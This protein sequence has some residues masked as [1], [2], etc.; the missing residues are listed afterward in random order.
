MRPRRLV[1]TLLALTLLVVPATATAKT[2]RAPAL[3]SPAAGALVEGVPAITW[4]AVKGAVAYEYQIAADPGF[5]S[6]V[7]GSGRGKGTNKTTNSAAALTSTLPDGDYHWRVR[8]IDTSDRAGRWSAT[9]Q[10][11]KAWTTA[12]LLLEPADDFAVQWPSLPLVLRWSPVPY[13]TRYV[14][15]IATDQ[16][17]ASPVIGTTARPQ[18]TQGT[19]FALPA[20][21]ANG[22]RYYWA[23]TPRDADGHS[24]QRSRSGSFTWNW[25]SAT[26]TRFADLDGDPGVLD[27]LF[28]WDA[29]PGAA[30]YEVDVN[31][32]QD[33]SPSSRVCCT[34]KTIGT[35][36]AP[37]RPFANNDGSNG[38]GYYW[39]M[40]AFDAGGNAGQWNYDPAF[41]PKGFH[42]AA[43]SIPNIQVRDNTFGGLSGPDLSTSAPVVTW[44]PVAGA[45][46][47]E[48]QLAPWVSG[49]SCAWTGPRIETVTGSTAW[50]PTESGG[51]PG[52]SSWPPLTPPDS[53]ALQ[54]GTKY[55]VRILA[56]SDR[57]GADLNGYISPFTTVAPAFT[58]TAPDPPTP[59]PVDL[60]MSEADYLFPVTGTFPAGSPTAETPLFRWKRVPWA[61][62]YYVVIARD[63]NFTQVVDIARTKIPAYAPR[64]RPNPGVPLVDETTSYYWAVM[65]VGPGEAT[66]PISEDNAQSFDKRSIPPAAVS[67]AQDAIVS[68]QP[69]FR[70][71]PRLGTRRYQLQVSQDP[72]FAADSLI[73][74]V[75]TSST[76]YTSS[77]TYPAD[78]VVYW[79]LRALDENLKGQTWSCRAPV[80][81]RCAT[82]DPT[83][84]DALKTYY[85]SFQRVLP[86][87]SPFSGNPTGGLGIPVLSWNPVPGAISYD[88]HADWVDGRT[89]DT[90][91]SSTAFTPTSFFGNGIWRWKVR[92][93]F[94]SGA[95]GKVSGGYFPAQDY[96]RR[97]DRTPNVRGENTSTR[98]LLSWDPD[99]AAAR[100]R[101]EISRSNAFGRTL[102]QVDTRT[103]AFAPDIASGAY[104][105]G[106]TYHW[107]VAS[108]D[109][110]R[111]T[112]AW[113][114]GTFVLPKAFRVTVS[115]LLRKGRRGIATAFVRGADRR[116][117]RGARVRVTG[118]G[119]RSATRKTNREGAAAFKLRP[120]RASTLTFTITRKGYRD[121]T[122]TLVVR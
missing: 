72:S 27:P 26:K 57:P 48:V 11:T 95:S 10:F 60:S 12:P 101:V 36:V 99:P 50:T 108:V 23:I 17:L 4:S 31:F 47:Y 117:V 41:F 37:T 106:G 120:R 121:A 100:Y 29:V 65:P 6:V 62:G 56:R 34:D 13:A 122:A 20:S 16:A 3:V 113:T 92:A 22:Q 77:T 94:P 14:V 2:L 51:N 64:L 63:S 90:T 87:P 74:D 83:N 105:D 104:A 42:A 98:V 8:A 49:S 73:D 21:L 43:P 1:F 115:G 70:W 112:G 107:R 82:P 114:T 85:S 54:L 88:V 9:R 75:Q 79:R 30:S 111:N 52:P 93:N 67:P 58:Y 119:L 84:V 33:F 91:V 32:S 38:F 103:T 15:T 46:S 5:G 45:G 69:T 68:G 80:S 7:L 81:G 66:G 86:V 109:D 40:R 97:M 18:T 35:S 19:S 28:S 78:G 110:G 116:A 61:V 39:R 102:D 76:A 53:P 44:D 71:T 89:S 25:P 96:V 55:C 118:R 59:P 24:G